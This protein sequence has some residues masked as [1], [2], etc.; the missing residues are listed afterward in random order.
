MSLS[1]VVVAILCSIL[2]Q[3]NAQNT[4]CSAAALCQSTTVSVSGY[5]VC[6]GN[7][8]CDGSDLYSTG[9][10]IY[11]R[12]H[13]SCEGASGNPSN[14]VAYN[15]VHCESYVSCIYG[16]MQISGNGVDTDTGGTDLNTVICRGYLSC[17]L[18]TI[19]DSRYSYVYC[20]SQQAC[21]NGTIANGNYAYICMGRFNL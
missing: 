8:V 16:Y 17:Y 1:S 14:L 5:I 10:H 11:C 12:G 3:S 13:Y 4:V 19:I 6:E 21:R 9:S 7:R 15:D 20:Y 2:R 18:S